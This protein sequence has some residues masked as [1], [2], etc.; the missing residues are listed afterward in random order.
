MSGSLGFNFTL[1]VSLAR[2]PSGEGWLS[3]GR[4]FCRRG[5]RARIHGKTLLH[6]K[7]PLHVRNICVGDKRRFTQ[8]S[9]PFPVFL[10][11]DV[12]FALFAAQN[13]TGASHFKAL[14]DG[15]SGF[16]LASFAG[17][18]SGV[19]GLAVPNARFFVK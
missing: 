14:G 2:G 10:L 12:T 9:F 11:E 8:H 7:I 19:L 18:G 1:I 5:H 6:E 4:P 13:L 3:R 16:G 15:R 17:H